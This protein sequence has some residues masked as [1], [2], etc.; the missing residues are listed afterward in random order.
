MEE[1]TKLYYTDYSMENGAHIGLAVYVETEELKYS[2]GFY[3]K[4]DYTQE[5]FNK[6]VVDMS[7]EEVKEYIKEH[8]CYR[9][10]GY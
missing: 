6:R 3:N 9:V 4:P 10:F 8:G 1:Y 2:L 5:E 7:S